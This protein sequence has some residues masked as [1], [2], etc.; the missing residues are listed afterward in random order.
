MVFVPTWGNTRP[1]VDGRVEGET[2]F[3]VRARDNGVYMVPSVYDGQSMVI[4]P[5]GRILVASEG[6]EGVFWC[7]V[8]LNE[9]EP[10]PWVGHW[11]DIGGRD[12]M[13]HTYAP[14]LQE[15]RTGR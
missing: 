15:P 7:E 8:D 5:M 11:H 4:D 14:L 13:P 2:T 10:L 6:K 1:D 9:R 12:R 3:R